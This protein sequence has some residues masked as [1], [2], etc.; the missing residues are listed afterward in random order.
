M[1]AAF[2]AAF[3][4]A[5]AGCAGVAEKGGQVL[6]G[7]AFAEKTLAVYRLFAAGSEDSAL[8]VRQVL[9]EGGEYLV[10]TLKAFPALAFYGTAPERDGSFS[11]RSARFLEGTAA[12]WNE[13][14]FELAGEGVFLV[15][16]DTGK[17]G[18]LRVTPPLE[19]RGLT[20]GKIRHKGSRFTG[21]GALGRL[22][23][24]QDRISALIDWMHSRQDAPA[25]EKRKDFEAYWK[26]LMLP[27]TVFPWKRPASFTQEQAVW[28]RGEDIRWNARYTEALFPEDLQAL[29]NS[30][31]LLRDWEEAGGWIYTRYQ[32]DYI[33]A[34]MAEQYALRKIK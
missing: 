24:R 30:G 28:V 1:L 22:R 7:S 25:F 10:I 15:E 6:D 27:E 26:P 29:R 19:A 20:E 8:E 33:T 13:F 31:A 11:L 4:F 9:R 3:C 34:L 12:G 23:N 21:S 2:G 5:A 32:W 17:A 18:T 16:G 14:A